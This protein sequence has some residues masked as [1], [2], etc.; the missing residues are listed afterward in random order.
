MTPRGSLCVE[1]VAAAPAPRTGQLVAVARRKYIFLWLLSQTQSQ[2]PL[3]PSWKSSLQQ[4]A[5][6]T[7]SNSMIFSTHIPHRGAWPE[8][9]H[10]RKQTGASWPLAVLEGSGVAVN[11][12]FPGNTRCGDVGKDSP[13]GTLQEKGQDG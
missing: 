13:P 3:H 12:P 10:S 1:R 6:P 9:G 11:W 8:P 5:N 2:S 4:E 7:K